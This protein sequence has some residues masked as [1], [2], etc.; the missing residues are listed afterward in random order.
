MLEAIGKI[1]NQKGYEN[2]YLIPK[3]SIDDPAGSSREI[4]L[5][6]LHPALGIYVIEVKNWDDLEQ[7][8]ENNPYE[9][10]KIYQRMLLAKIES[11]LKKVPINVEYRVIFPSISKAETSKFYAK[12]PSYLNLKNHTFFRD[13]L[14][15][16][17]IF[18]KFF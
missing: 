8:D 14:I 13:D 4:D 17:S 12:N 9:Q 16:E 7:L 2:Y 10:V 15:D 5:L 18:A 11:V 1:L 3:A 6:L